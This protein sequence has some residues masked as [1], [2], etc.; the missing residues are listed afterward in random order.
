MTRNSLPLA[1]AGALTLG[2][3]VVETYAGSRSPVGSSSSRD[4]GKPI[5]KPSKG[6][7]VRGKPGSD[8]DPVVGRIASLQAVPVGVAVSRDDRVFL[9]FSRAID[10]TV[11]VSV[12]E[13]VDDETVPYPPGFE[14]RDGNPAKNRLLS[15]QS[16]T[17]DA[18]NRLWILDTGRVGTNAVEP[19]SVRLVCWDLD[20]EELVRTIV[21]PK[22]VAGETSFINDVRVDLSRGRAGV[23]YLTDASAEGPNGLVVVDLAS[24]KAVRRLHDHAS[25]KPDGRLVLA[26]GEKKLVQRA[27]PQKGEPLRLGADGLAI[28]GKHVYWTPLTSHRLYRIRADVLADLGKSEREVAAAVEDLGDK[29]FAADG[30]L[31]DAEGR[32]YVTDLEN[33]KV[34]RRDARGKWTVISADDRLHWPDSL[35]MTSKGR[36]LVTATQIDDG[37]RIAGWDRRKRPFYVLQIATDST[38]LFLGARRST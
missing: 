3:C 6:K 36:L 22:A 24:G 4:D 27:G 37:K 5:R 14:Q 23:A 29:G 9:A 19:G 33:G 30:M 11:P 2:S 32:L 26:V 8:E 20:E 17:V 15:V 12:V 1:L 34:H 31:G 38:P 18:Q 16:L 7:P 13:L 28:A 10:E 25:T 21:L 35:A